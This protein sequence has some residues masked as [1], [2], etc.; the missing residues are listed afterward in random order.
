MTNNDAK[1]YASDYDLKRLA[2]D[3]IAQAVKDL[4]SKDGK[5]RES[6]NEFFESREN[7]FPQYFWCLKVCEIN[8]NFVR[9][10][11]QQVREGK[12]FEDLVFESRTPAYQ[13]ANKKKRVVRGEDEFSS[14]D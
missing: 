11:V 5:N 12:K 9:R 1:Y 4:Q 13:E 3:I 2:I 7:I 6:A 8:P 14:M 10:L